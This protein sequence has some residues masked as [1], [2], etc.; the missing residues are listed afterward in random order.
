[1]SEDSEKRER[2]LRP[3]RARHIS[4][5]AAVLIAAGILV[6]GQQGASHRPT[7]APPQNFDKLAAEAEAATEA[8]RAEEAIE[9]YRKAVALRPNWSEGWWNLG[10]LS[11]DS[12]K[13][14][15][16]H[17]AFLRFVTVEQRQPGPGF[18]MLGITEYELKNYPQALIA[19]E[20]GLHFGVGG[21]SEFAQHV[22][23]LDGILQNLLSKPEIALLR[24]KQVANQ[25]AAVHAEGS[26]EA[27]LA[28]SALLDAFGLA[29]LRMRMLPAQIPENRV[30]LVREAGHAQVLIV[31]QHPGE[32][33]AEL[34]ELVSRYENVPGVHYMY[35]VYLLRAQ[36]LSAVE[37]FRQE[38][39]V[40]PRD[41]AAYIQLAFQFLQGSDYQ[42]GLK[43]G[44]Q[45]V[46]LAPEDFAA[47]VAY[48][49]L[50]LELGD[51]KQALV[52]LRKA[53]KLS[54]ESPD[55][56]FALSR[57]LASAGQAHEATQEGTE[58]K[59][60]KA[61]ADAADRKQ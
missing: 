35:G 26:K 9:L 32:A 4:M 54:P 28:D 41:A 8:N 58:F 18:G 55:A 37:E 34:K 36:P 6:Y 30:S 56:H 49:R 33:G 21:N 50:L 10:T 46:A 27:V 61:L 43:Y 39:E 5:A 20:R 25:I 47:H 7:A 3:R 22:L 17:D 31:L 44:Q 1:M 14:P 38:I 2:E 52:E 16:A 53:V 60:L 11:Y 19:M 12:G 29:A 45:A 40:S 59:R 23:F 57:A 24:F 15:E 13:I 42:Q 51:T 48:G